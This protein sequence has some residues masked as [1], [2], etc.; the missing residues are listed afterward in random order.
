MKFKKNLN[1]VNSINSLSK[2][3]VEEDAKFYRCD[4]F[5]DFLQIANFSTYDKAQIIN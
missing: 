5:I 3:L 4:S 2:G 1:T